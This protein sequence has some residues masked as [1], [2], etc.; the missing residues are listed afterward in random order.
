MIEYN[1]L[2]LLP[3]RDAM[4]LLDQ[5]FLD[6]EVAVGKK[7]FR[8]DEWFFQGHYPGNPIVPGVIL[9]EVLGQS[10]CALFKDQLQGKLPYFTGL[11]KVKF[12]N[13][14]LPGDELTTRVECVR[15]MANVYFIKAEGYVGDT[16]CVS[17]QLSFAVVAG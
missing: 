13:P 2:E 8:G 11:D 17:G 14:V 15:S 10:A 7:R 4:L 1:V 16:L 6:G 12:K 5:V 9:C 3:H